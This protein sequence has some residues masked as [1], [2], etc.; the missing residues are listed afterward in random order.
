[1]EVM[2]YSPAIRT[3]S[4][5][6]ASRDTSLDDR[7]EHRGVHRWG[8]SLL[9]IPTGWIP[10]QSSALVGPIILY[11][12]P[13]R[14]ATPGGRMVHGQ[15]CRAGDGTMGVVVGTDIPMFLG[16]DRRPATASS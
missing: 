5:P 8:L 13:I 12:L 1:M 6:F 4:P 11:L 9:F 10:M 2:P 15:R 7:A 16:D 14:S 3:A